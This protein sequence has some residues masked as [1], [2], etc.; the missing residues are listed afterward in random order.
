MDCLSSDTFLDVRKKVN[1]IPVYIKGDKQV[2]IY[3]IRYHKLLNP[4]QSRFKKNDS[5]I[6]QIV[7]LTHEIYCSLDFKPSVDVRAVFLD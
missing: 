5:S 6:N 7:S 4:Y 2:T 3:S 1:V